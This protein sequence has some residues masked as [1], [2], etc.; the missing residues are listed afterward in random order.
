MVLSF[1]N[2]KKKNERINFRTD[3]EMLEKL[4]YLVIEAKRTDEKASR[5]SVI[6]ALIQQ[7]RLDKN[8]SRLKR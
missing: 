1:P 8:G 2:R 6:E 7:A 5:T 4:D 3:V